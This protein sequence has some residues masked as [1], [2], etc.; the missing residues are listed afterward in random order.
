ML[1]NPM[2]DCLLFVMYLHS[3]NNV[4][5]SVLKLFNVCNTSSLELNNVDISVEWLFIVC[6]TFKPE[7]Y[8]EESIFVVLF[9]VLYPLTSKDDNNVVYYLM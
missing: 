5:K 9:N 7:T 1:I 4:D 8:K 2:N 6:N 3:S